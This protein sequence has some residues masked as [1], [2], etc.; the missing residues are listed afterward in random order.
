MSKEQ[1]NGRNKL[2]WCIR[3]PLRALC[4]L[5]DMYVR[6]MNGCA[7]RIPYRAT[8]SPVSHPF[9]DMS[10]SS[11]VSNRGSRISSADEDLIELIRASSQ[12]RMRSAA[13]A[14]AAEEAVVRRS[15]SVA[16]ARIEEDAPYDFAG[17]VKV[18]ESLI[19]PRSR[20][21]AVGGKTALG[22]ASSK[23]K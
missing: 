12:S 2:G 5:R 20:S 6:T 1:R 19:F 7:G 17:D 3:A 10:R 15:Q 16:A 21:H 4:R 23:Y 11:S 9:I 18:G 22:A 14:A 13:V 8:A